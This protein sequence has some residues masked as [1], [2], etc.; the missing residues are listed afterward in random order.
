MKVTE[1]VEVATEKWERS[2]EHSYIGPETI[3]MIKV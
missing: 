1:T 3:S 2:Y